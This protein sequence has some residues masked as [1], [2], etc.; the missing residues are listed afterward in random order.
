M[1]TTGIWNMLFYVFVH[2]E[3]HFSNKLFDFKGRITRANI[4][5]VF[6][7][8]ANFWACYG[9][10]LHARVIFHVATLFVF[11]KTAP[12]SDKQTQNARILRLL[13]RK[14]CSF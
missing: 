9:Y 7:K 1:I 11:T 6:L 5:R 13:I 14:W 2:F 8:C 12:F 4:V 10:M 3:N